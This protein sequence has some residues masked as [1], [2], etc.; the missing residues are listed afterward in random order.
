MLDKV[1]AIRFGEAKESIQYGR[2][3]YFK[4]SGTWKYWGTE[5]NFWEFWERIIKPNK[6]QND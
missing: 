4:V 2:G 1:E 6:S 3:T 5:K